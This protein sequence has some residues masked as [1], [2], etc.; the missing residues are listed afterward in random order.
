M[1]WAFGRSL[2][3]P[4]VHNELAACFACVGRKEDAQRLSATVG[5]CVVGPCDCAKPAHSPEIL[6][7]EI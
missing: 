3:T 7:A 5:A 2:E 6:V 1:L 4:Y